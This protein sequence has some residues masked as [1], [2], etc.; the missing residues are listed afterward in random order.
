MIS[1]SST[2]YPLKCATKKND[3]DFLNK[4]MLITSKISKYKNEI[5]NKPKGGNKFSKEERFKT[6]RPETPGPGQ[7]DINNLSFGKGVPKYSINT[8]NKE[9][10]IHKTIRLSKKNNLPGP[11]DY[12]ITKENLEKTILHRTISCFFSKQQPKLE[13]LEKPKKIVKFESQ[14]EKEKKKVEKCL[15][16]VIYKKITELLDKSQNNNKT[17]ENKKIIDIVYLIDSTTSMGIEV[18]ISSKMMI[19]ISRKLQN[20]Y[21]NNDYQFGIIFYNDPVANSSGFNGYY[22]L[23]KDTKKLK[24]FSDKWTIQ[25]GVDFAEDWVGGYEIALSE[26][27]WRN[28]DKIIVHITDAPGHGKKY[29]KGCGDYYEEE[30][31]ELQLD[32]IMERCAKENIKIIG[33]Y[34]NSVSK[35]CFIECKKVYDKSNGTDF[36]IEYYLNKKIIKKLY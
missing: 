2:A 16:D 32:N 33:I 24:E 23:T 12:T 8:T 1:R 21:K 11:C 27:K 20:N 6:F 30:S 14:Y 7:Y 28:G 4:T 34:K 35:E 31:F 25:G 19:N 5:L 3:K 10:Q 22:Q 36:T 13:K 9:T 29:S 18:E 17:D 15:P 26:I